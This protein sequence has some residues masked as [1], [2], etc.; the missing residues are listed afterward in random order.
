VKRLVAAFFVSLGIHGLFLFS[1]LNL[2]ARQKTDLRLPRHLTVTLSYTSPP[3]SLSESAE[4]P[5]AQ[6][7]NKSEPHK[8]RQPVPPIIPEPL[9]QKAV[10]AA[11]LSESTPE[12]ERLQTEPVKPLYGHTTTIPGKAVEAPPVFLHESSVQELAT[13]LPAKPITIK[14]ARPAYRENPPPPYPGSARR[15]GVEGSVLLEV[16]VD[17]NGKVEQVKIFKSS[18]H[19]V[20]DRAALKAVGAWVFE[21][22]MIGDR[23]VGMWVRVPIRFELK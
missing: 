11:L 12:P 10:Q 13:A 3:K 6:P 21:P 7:I 5:L 17:S 15:R 20:L 14:E 1:D 23:P 8:V 16:L 22:G 9:P 19:R 2:S 18:G 4:N